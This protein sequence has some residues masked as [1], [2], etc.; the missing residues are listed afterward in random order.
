MKILWNSVAPWVGSGY[1]AQT[2]MFAPRIRDAGHDVALSAI[3]GLQD[4]STV[5]DGIKVYPA[6]YTQLNTAM[7]PHYAQLH[8]D[9]PDASDVQIIMLLD[10]WTLVA[11]AWGRRL[12]QKGLRYACWVPVDH[13]PV[14]PA[15]L[16]GL[17][18]IDA[19]PIAMSRF[20]EEALRD[21]GH[22]PLYVPHGVD[23][24]VMR[25]REDGRAAARERMGIPED[26]FL[27]GM[28]ANNSG[29]SPPRK[30]FPQVFQA[31][32]RLAAERD[33][34]YLY[35]HSEVTGI[36]QGINLLSLA[37]A[38]GIPQDRIKVVDQVAY[39]MGDISPTMLSCIYSGL[40]VLAN[41][42]YGEGFGIPIVEAQAC[43][44]PV[45]VSDW[46]AM[47][48]LVGAGWVV[49]GDAWYDCAHG[50]F[51]MCPS[52]NEIYQAMEMAYEARGTMRAQ[53]RSF[54]LG[55]D[56]DV[57]MRDYWTPVLAELDTKA[58]F[59]PESRQVKRARARKAEAV[60]A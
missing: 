23:T 13:Y 14:P 59:K 27:V 4:G 18:S 52:I 9:E 21:A 22:D 45:I 24:N 46:T 28:V 8:S 51:Y 54:A 42:S 29:D 47:P 36:R 43:G 15:V 39:M 56:A 33:D 60:S 1:G 30:A 37:E 53:A 55:Y 2:A 12:L 35:L 19:R 20:G 16:M 32:S 44:T 25:F 48:E 10:A 11:P 17:E 3:H 41:P 49:N 38:V 50:A 40:D 7:L 57:V 5:W 34:A 26:A 58:Q 6:D 31:F